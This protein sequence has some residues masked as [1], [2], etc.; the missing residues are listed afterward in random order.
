MTRSERIAAGPAQSRP[1]PRCSGAAAGLA[2]GLQHVQLADEVLAHLGD[3]IVE[4]GKG[5][6]GHRAGLT[7]DLAVEHHP[8]R[9][10]VA[11]LDRY[12][13]V[14]LVAVAREPAL[15]GREPLRDLG[16]VVGGE[17]AP[18]TQS[19]PDQAGA[20]ELGRASGGEQG[21]QYG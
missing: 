21:V 3:G 6:R 9:R 16:V 14:D 8:L 1:D 10:R 5:G 2:A 19:P 7:R 11:L 12:L 13:E 17:T 20:A 18:E 4:V 15:E